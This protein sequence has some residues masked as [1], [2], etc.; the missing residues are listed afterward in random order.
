M[1]SEVELKQKIK[2]VFLSYPEPKGFLEIYP[3]GPLKVVDDA[4]GRC[5]RFCDNKNNEF[6]SISVT[7]KQFLPPEI[8]RYFNMKTPDRQSTAKTEFSPHSSMSLDEMVATEIV[9]SLRQWVSSN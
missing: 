7:E 5:F 3:E 1:S 9:E 8:K 4:I 6:L 2:N